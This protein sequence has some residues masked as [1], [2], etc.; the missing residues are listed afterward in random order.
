MSLPRITA[1]R[2]VG[3][4]DGPCGA[5]RTCRETGALRHSAR[6][7]GPPSARIEGAGDVGL[8]G[9][10]MTEWDRGVFSASDVSRNETAARLLDGGS[11]RLATCR[12]P[13]CPDGICAARSP[14]DD[15]VGTVAR[16]TSLSLHGSG[17]P[18]RR[19]GPTGRRNTHR[20]GGSMRCRTTGT[21]MRGA[22]RRARGPGG[23]GTCAST[24][25]APGRRALL[26]THDAPVG[27][28]GRLGH[29]MHGRPR[30]ALASRP[31]S[32]SAALACG[33][34]Q[35]SVTGLR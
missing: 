18:C 34:R 16:K 27:M 6:V 11:K 19:S 32:G 13:T 22:S 9:P 14:G 21:T 15:A 25:M 28:R 8:R 30:A 17:T 24:A 29:H 33:R 2:G 26:S 31:A 3:R 35:S 20:S 7:P 10:G 23:P 5:A 4:P 1:D 12:G